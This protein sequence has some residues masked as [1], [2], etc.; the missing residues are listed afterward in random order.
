MGSETMANSL[1][2]ASALALMVTLAMGAPTGGTDVDNVEAL[3]AQLAAA[4]QGKDAALKE[5]DAA[6]NREGKLSKALSDIHPSSC[7]HLGK[8]GTSSQALHKRCRFLGEVT[9]EDTGLIFPN[10]CPQDSKKN[11]Y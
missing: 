4:L 10:G 1:A 6:L 2:L 3:K 11:C 5:K 8:A 9:A 7:R